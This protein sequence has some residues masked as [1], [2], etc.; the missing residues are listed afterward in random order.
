MIIFILLFSG[1]MWHLCAKQRLWRGKAW[2]T[3]EVFPEGASG[4]VASRFSCS[5]WAVS[6][7]VRLLLGE[8]TSCNRAKPRG[9]RGAASTGAGSPQLNT[10]T[11]VCCSVSQGCHRCFPGAQGNPQSS[12]SVG[13]MATSS[14]GLSSMTVFH[15][16]LCRF[17]D[18]LSEFHR[19]MALI[20]TE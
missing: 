15:W 7:P 14:F 18:L 11:I 3:A 13:P 9:E 6:G 5:G 16:C 12:Y 10:G 4:L 17:P 19:I 2:R 1:Q 8:I 20:V